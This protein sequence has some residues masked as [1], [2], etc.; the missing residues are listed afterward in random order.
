MDE[1][2]TR[3][4]ASDMGYEAGRVKHT[5]GPGEFVFKIS[6]VWAREWSKQTI[7]HVTSCEAARGGGIGQCMLGTLFKISSVHRWMVQMDREK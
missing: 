3:I 5:R 7:T 1:R 2:S 6:Q 4:V